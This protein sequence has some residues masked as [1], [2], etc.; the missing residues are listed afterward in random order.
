ML[1]VS[2]FVEVVGDAR[3][4]ALRRVVVALVVAGGAMGNCAND[5]PAGCAGS[6]VDGVGAV[7][8][9]IWTLVHR[10]WWR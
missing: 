7:A 5:G 9:V 6:D 4:L 8:A 10:E 3:L 1:V 2:T